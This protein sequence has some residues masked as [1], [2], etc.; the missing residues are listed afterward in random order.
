[1]NQAA[2]TAALAQLCSNILAIS[3]ALSLIST[4]WSGCFPK[5]IIKVY[6]LNIIY[7]IFNYI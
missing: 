1:M 4:A 5:V 6:L 3:R 7:N 2:A